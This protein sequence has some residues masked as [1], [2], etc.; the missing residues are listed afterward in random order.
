LADV[1]VDTEQRLRDAV[2]DFAGD[3]ENFA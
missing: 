1:V 3:R 2:R